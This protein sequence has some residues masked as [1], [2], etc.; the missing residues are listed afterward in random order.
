ME[1]ENILDDYLND[2]RF[3][4]GQKLQSPNA[5]PCNCIRYADNIWQF[6][7]ACMS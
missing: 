1:T 3:P 5:I 4:R 2:T 7:Q 6:A